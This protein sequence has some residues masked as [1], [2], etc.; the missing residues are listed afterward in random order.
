MHIE[1]LIWLFS[2]PCH[3]ENY[4]ILLSANCEHN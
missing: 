4:I 3:L 2:E 1:V